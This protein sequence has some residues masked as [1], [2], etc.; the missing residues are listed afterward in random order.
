MTEVDEKDRSEDSD[1]EE[2]F[3]TPT[4]VLPRL[5][6]ASADIAKKGNTWLID[7][8][9]THV[10]SIGHS[11]P[12]ADLRSKLKLMEIKIEDE[13]TADMSKHFLMCCKFIH[14]ARLKQDNICAI[15]SLRGISRSSTMT[16]GYYMLHLGLSFKDAHTILRGLRTSAQ[17]NE[18]FLQQLSAFEKE[19][20]KTK[21]PSSSGAN[22]TL[23]SA[24]LERKDREFLASQ[25]DDESWLEEWSNTRRRTMSTLTPEVAKKDEVLFQKF[26][27]SPSPGVAEGSSRSRTV[28][29][30]P[31]L[32]YSP[33]RPF[34]Y[35]ASPPGPRPQEIKKNQL[36]LS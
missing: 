33:I 10:L 1:E 18:G 7:N 22:G 21:L 27:G 30:L 36:L 28:S 23:D 9:V 31:S 19:T 2:E 17:P 26:V 4:E 15:Y 29:M 13:P 14:M 20:S 16:L 3:E 32:T 5:Y 25:S 6:L 35:P 34:A 11:L 24:E 8:K 12:D